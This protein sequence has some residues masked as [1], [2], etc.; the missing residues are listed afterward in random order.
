MNSSRKTLF[1]ASYINTKWTNNV[2]HLDLHALTFY[3][4]IT[5]ADLNFLVDLSSQ[6]WLTLEE[7]IKIN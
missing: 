7:L 4:S 1:E 6:Q 5:L 3:E 2:K